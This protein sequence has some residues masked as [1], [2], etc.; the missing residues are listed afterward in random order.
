MLENKYW[1]P[2]TD[3]VDDIVAEDFNNAF[4]TIENDVKNKV[5]KEDGKG[6]STEDFTTAEKNKLAGLEN[7]VLPSDVVKDAK[8]VHTDK[9]YT[10]E[11]KEKLA[12]LENNDDEQVVKNA[13]NIDL[14][15]K[16]GTTDVY[17]L[18]EGVDYTSENGIIIEMFKW[19][20]SGQTIAF[21]E[22][23]VSTG[24][25]FAPN[26]TDDYGSIVSTEYFKCKKLILPKTMEICKISS[27][28]VDEIDTGNV[29][30]I[31]LNSN[32]DAREKTAGQMP[33]NLEFGKNIEKIE[34]HYGITKISFKETPLSNVRIYAKASRYSVEYDI[35]I[36]L[37]NVNSYSLELVDEAADEVNPSFFTI[38]GYSG[39]D[40]EY[41]AR[42]NYINFVNIGSDYSAELGDIESAVDHIL[43]LDNALL[44]GDAL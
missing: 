8:Y 35:R 36:D 21:P 17:V 23:L 32:I 16:Y 4:Y 31:Y 14:I 34:L 38:Y 42:R 29:K 30:E 33:Y 1:T 10:T 20:Y 13:E 27:I 9:N 40:A 44:G 43:E 18:Q 15:D 2:K 39:S 11:E 22:G 12:R 7:Y 25:L 26:E 6:L 19:D 24:H 41:Y 28:W 37:R 5:D 3:N